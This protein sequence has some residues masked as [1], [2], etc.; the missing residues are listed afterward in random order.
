MDTNPR[1]ST[2]SVKKITLR[3]V[4]EYDPPFGRVARCKYTNWT[5]IANDDANL[6]K[7]AK[8]NIFGLNTRFGA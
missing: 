4:R 6:L 8:N 7:M 3:A 1:F 2:E 5:N